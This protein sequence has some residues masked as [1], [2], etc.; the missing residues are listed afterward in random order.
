MSSILSLLL[1]YNASPASYLAI[2]FALLLPHQYKVIWARSDHPSSRAQ[3]LRAL[4]LLVLASDEFFHYCRC[5]CHG[6]QRSGTHLG[7]LGSELTLSLNGSM[8]QRTR[9]T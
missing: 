5:Y 1:N 2:S 3:C 9:Y 6:G 4:L 7:R 8:M